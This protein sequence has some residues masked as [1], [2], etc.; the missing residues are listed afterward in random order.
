MSRKDR[1]IKWF[2]AFNTWLLRVSRGRL[3]NRLG[4]QRILLLQTTGR[5]SGRAH[6]IP[7]AYFE[8]DGRYVI[9]ASN[10][11]REQQ[12]NWYLNLKHDPRAVLEIRGQKQAV[13][14]REAEGDEYQALWQYV[15]E[16]HPPYLAY[17]RTTSRRIPVMLF[18]PQ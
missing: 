11:G 15:A 12:A 9:V 14:A 3:G 8:R 6:V 2:M 7:I 4:R 13:V 17:Q 10:W 1:F 18:S 5:K 16:R